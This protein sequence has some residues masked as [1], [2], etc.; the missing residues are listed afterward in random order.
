MI[1][2]VDSGIANIG[3]II[4]AFNRIGAQVKATT[5]PE[6]VRTA[7]ALILP[8]VGAFADG[9]TSLRTNRLVEPIREVVA[10][11]VPILGICLGMQLLA[12]IGE[13]F[14]E[15]EGLGLISGRVVRMQSFNQGERVPNIGWCDINLTK[16]SR[17]LYGI[18]D[19]SAFYFVHSYYVSCLD[20]NDSVGSIP[21]GSGLVTVAV[22]RSNIFGVQFHPEKSQDLGL[23]VLDNF[24]RLI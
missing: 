11:G 3:S 15:H 10:S 13:E 7:S 12:E 4:A 21:F 1:A 8:G 2:I 9:M 22:E 23:Q 24:V 6:V 19:G 16:S 17:L 14:G 18:K 20:L 5:D